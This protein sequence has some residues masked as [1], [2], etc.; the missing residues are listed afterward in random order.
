MLRYCIYKSCIPSV[1]KGFLYAGGIYE[2][3]TRGKTAM[4]RITKSGMEIEFDKETLR[5]SFQ[6]DDGCRWRWARSYAPYMECENGNVFF[7]DAGEITHELLH[8]G[9]GEGIL[10]TYGGFEEDGKAVPYTFQT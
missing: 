8:T 7:H 3:G 6:K 9:V 1:Y 10:S 2:K 4:N 5:F